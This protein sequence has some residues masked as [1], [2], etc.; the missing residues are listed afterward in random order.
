MP[1]PWSPAISMTDL[2]E[3]GK[4]GGQSCIRGL[5]FTVYGFLSLLASGES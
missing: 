3:A 2:R 4:R 1:V 5:R